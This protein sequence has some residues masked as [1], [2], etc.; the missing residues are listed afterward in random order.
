MNCLANSDVGNLTIDLS[1]SLRKLREVLHDVGFFHFYKSFG[2]GNCR[3][4]TWAKAIRFINAEDLGLVVRCFLLGEQVE[5]QGLRRVLGDCLEYPLEQ[6]DLFVRKGD[7]VACNYRLFSLNGFDF[8][9][10][11]G[12]LSPEVYFGGDSV[13]LAKHQSCEP[14]GIVVDLCSG[15]GIQGMIASR[16]SKHVYCVEINERAARIAAL[17]I[18]MNH[19]GNA[20][21]INEDGVSF[22][23]RS[24]TE[25]N[26]ILFNPPLLPV[27]STLE[28]PFVGAG[29]QDGL[30]LTKNFIRNG[31]PR[32]AQ[33][34]KIEFV[35]TC[36]ADTEGRFE[37][38]TFQQLLEKNDL[39]GSIFVYSHHSLE[40]GGIFHDLML[41]T[42]SMHSGQPLALVRSH[43]QELFE[44]FGAKKILCMSMRLTKRQGAASLN[45]V[46]LSCGAYGEWFS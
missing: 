4:D 16:D 14:D 12:P 25:I 6:T 13:A 11:L 38:R 5:L 19:V 7:Q 15:S 1:G 30:E 46:D 17:N 18:A 34:G 24:S 33:G 40:P 29:G 37:D 35:G 39:S 3:S 31:A 22:L 8:F 45:Y 32:L 26:H 21:V 27:P 41:A 28:Y 2:D 42:T 23:K 44:K 20:T 10:Q 36:F 43:Y 9:A